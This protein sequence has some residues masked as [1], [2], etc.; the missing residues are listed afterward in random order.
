MIGP[1]RGVASRLEMR[2]ESLSRVGLF[3][4]LAIAQFAAHA[5]S[6]TAAEALF[7][8]H[9]GAEALAVYLVLVG[10]LVVPVAGALA[11][12]IDRLPKTT[13]YRVSLAIAVAGAIALRALTLVDSIVTWYAVLI[14]V[15]LMEILLGLQF[16]VLI[17]EYF[18]SLEQKK[19][20]TVFIIVRSAGG[21]LGAGSANFLV[22]LVGTPNLLLIFPLLF[23]VAGAL[24]TALARKETPLESEAVERET[25]VTSALRSLPALLREY[26]IIT[27]LA[28]VGF[29]DVLLSSVGSVLS[30][31]IFADAYPD[32]QQM[33]AFLGTLK[34]SLSVL[35][36]VTILFVTRPLIRKLGVGSMNV[37]F[38]ATSLGALL[39]MAIRPAVPAAVLA[40]ATFDSIS[41]SLNNPVENLTYNAV[42]PRFLGRVRSIS[43]GVLQ[44]SGLLVGG[45]VLYAIQ[46]RLSFA[47]LAWITVG[48]AA[49][50]TV[51][52]FWRGR[53][54]VAA[55]SKQI[56]SSAIDF[57]GRDGARIEVPAAYAEEVDRLLAGAD[58]ETRAF[59]LELA[60]RLGADHFFPAARPVLSELEGRGREA[61]VNFLAALRGKQER[62][63]L[64]EL[65]RSGTP[66]VQALVLE[67]MLRLEVELDEATLAPLLE[68]PDAKVRGL[69]RAVSLRRPAKAG[70]LLLS[71]PNLG[72]EGLASMARGARAAADPQLVPALV[73]AMM[74]GSPNTRASALEGL[75]AVSPLGERYGSVVDLAELELESEEPRVRAAAYALLGTE[76]QTR[77]AL[78]AKGLEDTH[79]LVRRRVSTVLGT[80]GEPAIPHLATALASPRPEVV[81]AALS[82]LGA[83]RRESAADAAL[84][85]LADDFARIERNRAWRRMLPRGDERWR[86]LEAVLEDSDRRAVNQALRVLAAFGHSRILR[87]ARQALRGRDVRLRANAVEALASIPQRRFVLPILHLLEALASDMAATAS[88]RGGALRLDDL[89]ASP[90]RWVRLAAIEVAKAL[91]QP[92]PAALLTDPDP[93]VRETAEARVANKETLM[94]RLLFLRR[95]SLFQDLSLDDLLALDESLRRNDY[96]AEETI[97]EEGTVGDDF[98]LVSEGEVSVR[99]GRDAAQREVA[100]LGPGDF[101]GEMALFDDEPRSATCVAA[102][103]CTLL[104]LDRSRFYSLIE[105]LPQL[106]VAI[107]RT[108]SQRL[109]RTERDLRA[110]RA[111]QPG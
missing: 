107:C 3:C 45:I 2:E 56:S 34:A 85:F 70:P 54:Y 108:L 105:Q 44:P 21:A 79:G 75:V 13:V 64:H 111:G 20:M 57:S 31:R 67:A 47:Q 83:V 91:E 24:V 104:V 81:D 26:P 33:T 53:L 25:A 98:Y 38:P 76:D 1:L 4:G 37:I 62:G 55:L 11:Q 46:S 78:V 42:P 7:L 84:K 9:A 106:G 80:I 6:R 58:Q 51:L 12:Y 65:L 100:R 110:V 59:G 50:H 68:N 92:T 69:A 15:V 93:L 60:A 43:E 19:L 49:L 27:L 35:E 29:F 8:A 90:D 30:Y 32:E 28:L 87:H 99:A 23:V 95:I 39:G 72:D 14:G 82:A 18:T 5:L 66:T 88:G 94:S 73:E 61:G 16:W 101:F 17:S 22:G 77:L 71:D 109:R 97:F 89:A 74:R 86:A 63:E 103:P 10:V 36:V 48:V 102:T 96:L 52:G 40:S 41:S